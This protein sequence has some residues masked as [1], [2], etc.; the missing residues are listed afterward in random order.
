LCTALGM[1]MRK[2]ARVRRSHSG[3]P[4]VTKRVEAAPSCSICSCASAHVALLDG[5]RIATAGWQHCN[6][7]LDQGL[8]LSVYILPVR[9]ARACGEPAA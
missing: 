6:A 9:L 4:E 3:A 7:R 8:V 1:V 2:V 5:F